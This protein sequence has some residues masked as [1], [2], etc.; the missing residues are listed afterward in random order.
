MYRSSNSRKINFRRETLKVLDAA[1][2][3]VVG[4]GPPDTRRDTNYGTGC[5]PN[6]GSGTMFCRPRVI[7]VDICPNTHN[8]EDRC[9]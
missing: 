6:M 8:W 9:S 5:P 4:G 1:M 7:S 3:D 2:L